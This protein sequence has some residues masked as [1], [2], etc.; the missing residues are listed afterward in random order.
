MEKNPLEEAR[1]V[2]DGADRDM[3]ALFEK[4]MAAAAR[5]ARFK[6][7]NGL[8]IR[9]AAREEAVLQAGAERVSQEA[10]RP[11]YR[12]FLRSLMALSRQYQEELNAPA[13]PRRV[14]VRLGERGYT[15]V[16]QRGGL[17]NAG[18]FFNLDRPAF[19]VTDEGVPEEYARTVAAQCRRSEI[20]RLPRG[21]A[22]KTFD[23]LQALLSRMLIFGL[24]RGGCVVAV[25]GGAV[26]DAAGFAAACYM[27]GVDFYNI[28]TTLLAQ[29][30][31]SVG[32]KTA[33]DLDGVKNAAGAFHQPRGVLADPD[34]LS[35]LPPRQMG[36]GLAEALK[37]AACF[38]EK[39]FSLLEGEDPL[40]HLDEIIENALRI[41]AAVVEADETEAG[42]RRALNFGHTLGHGIESAQGEGGLLHGECVALGM[43]P[44]C[45]EAA[46]PRL[47]AALRRL[48]L[49]TR[50]PVH[51][52]RVMAAVCHDKKMTDG[53]ITA[54]W[55]DQIGSFAFRPM[56]PGEL[57]ARYIACFG[58]DQP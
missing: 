14:P 53:K 37:M 3:A 43:L 56:T 19:I 1:R 42:L 44:L 12:S 27:R 55:V 38:D 48:H 5:I 31:A 30:D 18:A 41:K 54:V 57:R 8:P 58:E 26:G 40:S 2:I 29:V 46:R 20:F 11:Y 13:L 9:D 39:G 32:G 7:E 36:N 16:L 17:Q 4:R 25:G 51:P 6:R 50:C 34:L 22:A 49:P 10:L 45:A 15:V 28:P 52:D 33:V 24:D 23:C 35:T 47:L 21:E